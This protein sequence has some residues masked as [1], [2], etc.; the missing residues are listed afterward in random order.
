MRLRKKAA[1]AAAAPPSGTTT[2][3][4]VTPERLG[5]LV[6]E[7]QWRSELA[8]CDQALKQEAASLAQAKILHR[9]APIGGVERASSL[10]KKIDIHT[11][12]IEE[13]KTIRLELEEH[14]P[15]RTGPVLEIV[16]GLATPLDGNGPYG[17]A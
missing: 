10:A 7:L 12:R 8:V 15:I 4:S 17:V 5:E 16:Q 1:P 3:E 11:R 14:R 2:P 13:L 6:D 9:L